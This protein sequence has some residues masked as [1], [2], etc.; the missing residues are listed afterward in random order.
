M[1]NRDRFVYIALI[2]LCVGACWLSIHV[3]SVG[4]PFFS[5]KW[6]LLALPRLL[7]GLLAGASLAMA[8]TMF[9]A[10]FRN[11]LASPYTLGVSSGAS[12]G[13]YVAILTVG[14][15][16]W[17]GL[18][19]VSL[20]VGL[21]GIFMA[22]VIYCRKWITAESVGKFFGPLYTLVYRKY[23][24]DEFYE[25]IIVKTVLMKWLFSGFTFFDSKGVDGAVNGIGTAVT[26]T[27][28]A[29]RHA[30]TG[31]LQLY[32]LFIGIGIAVIAICV[33]IFG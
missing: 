19:V 23:F 25:G 31:Q 12:L 33:Y 8:G 21:F 26:S 13:A 16:L 15:G 27:G 14:S 10:L 2:A 29:I 7:M 20:V 32:G 1:T 24:F 6:E 22:Y 9:Q 18:P 28:R 11:P 5:A 4:V 17:L 3:G 30:Q